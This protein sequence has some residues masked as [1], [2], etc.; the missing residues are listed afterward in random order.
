[1]DSR[2]GSRRSEVGNSKVDH[3]AMSSS[4]DLKP[5]ASAAPVASLASL[6]RVNYYGMASPMPKA[7][8]R[9]SA[10]HVWQ[11]FSSPITTLKTAV[12][13]Q[14]SA[15]FQVPFIAGMHV[16]EDFE[17][18]RKYRRLTIRLLATERYGM[19]DRKQDAD[20]SPN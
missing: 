9:P 6:A 8:S 20:G 4:P 15:K 16:G 2:A 11:V 17:S 19:P 7:H 14:L 12:S 1:M 5:L 13:H 3:K 10:A 18:E